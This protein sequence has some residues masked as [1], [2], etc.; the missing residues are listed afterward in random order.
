VIIP[1]PGE[2]GDISFEAFWDAYDKKVGKKEKISRKWEKRKKADRL[3]IMSY[4]EA[5]KQAN[6]D[7]KYRKNPETFLNNESWNDEII[8]P[9]GKE[10][11]KHPF[12]NL[13]GNEQ[14]EKF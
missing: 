3:K 11:R 7:K 6:P 2:D 13:H 12:A 5:Y 1:P 4:I 8:T 14:Y 9:A 10:K